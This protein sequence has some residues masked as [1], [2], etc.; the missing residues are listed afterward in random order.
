MF[1]K[2][3]HVIW[4]LTQIYVGIST[5]V[6]LYDMCVTGSPISHILGYS[7]LLIIFSFLTV[8]IIIFE[9]IPDFKK[10]SKIKAS[11]H[12]VCQSCVYCSPDE[13]ICRYGLN[14]RSRYKLSKCPYMEKK[15]E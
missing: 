11:M 13:K 12:S 15:S 5:G 9:I 3:L 1:T 2:I 10:K 14:D 8:L 7:L 4:L 6:K